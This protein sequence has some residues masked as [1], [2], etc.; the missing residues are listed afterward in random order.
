MPIVIHLNAVLGKVDTMVVAIVLMRCA[1]NDGDAVASVVLVMVCFT[2]E[3]LA[4]EQVEDQTVA[5]GEGA[6]TES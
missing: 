3:T 2:G 6:L 1:T 4:L 5:L